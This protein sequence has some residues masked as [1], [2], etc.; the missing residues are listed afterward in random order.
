MVDLFSA[1]GLGKSTRRT[2]YPQDHLLHRIRLGNASFLEVSIII[3]KSKIKSNFSSLYHKVFNWILFCLL[4][5]LGYCF[6]V[7]CLEDEVVVFFFQRGR[8]LQKPSPG[9]LLAPLAFPKST[10]N[11]KYSTSLHQEHEREQTISYRGSKTDDS[12]NKAGQ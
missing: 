8:R 6:I 1:M 7:F 4:Y 5:S 2:G 10:L 12:E 11:L 3:S 9:S